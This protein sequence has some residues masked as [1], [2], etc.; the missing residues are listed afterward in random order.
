MHAKSKLVFEQKYQEFVSQFSEHR[1]F[2]KY[3]G[4]SRNFWVDWLVYMLSQ[5]VEHDYRQEGLR[6]VYGFKKLVLTHTEKAKK[7]KAQEIVYE[8]ALSMVK[9]VEDTLGQKRNTVNLLL[10]RPKSFVQAYFLVCRMMEPQYSL[11]KKLPIVQNQDTNLC[12]KIEQAMTKQNVMAM[13]SPCGMDVSV[14][15]FRDCLSSLKEAGA[16]PQQNQL[17]LVACV[18]PNFGDTSSSDLFLQKKQELE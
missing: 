9:A 1:N 6:I 2:V 8:D 3:I 5:V 18:V 15:I 4:R 17:F 11:I 13:D 12:K 16:G 7:K 10:F 14:Q